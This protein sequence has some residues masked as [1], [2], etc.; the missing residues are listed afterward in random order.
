MQAPQQ[1]HGDVHSIVAPGLASDLLIEF[2]QAQYRCSWSST[3]NGNTQLYTFKTP[4]HVLVPI[5]NT[6]CFAQSKH[7]VFSMAHL[8]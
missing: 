5:R 4:S 1:V 6:Q 2:L 7:Y 3:G 8:L